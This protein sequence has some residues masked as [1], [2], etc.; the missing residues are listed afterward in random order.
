MSRGEAC[1][2][3]PALQQDQKTVEL[4]NQRVGKREILRV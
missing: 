3:A 1:P 4:L 2:G